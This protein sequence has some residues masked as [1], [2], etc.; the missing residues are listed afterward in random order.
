MFKHFNPLNMLQTTKLLPHLHHPI[1]DAPMAWEGADKWIVTCSGRGLE[2]QGII[3]S[4]VNQW[5]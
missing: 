2:P 3:L 5:C 4:R 1:H